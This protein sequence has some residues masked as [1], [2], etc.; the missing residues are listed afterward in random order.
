MPVATLQRQDSATPVAPSPGGQVVSAEFGWTVVYDLSAWSVGEQYAERGYDYVELQSGSS[1]VTLESVIDQHGDPQ[2]CVTDELDQLQMLEDRAAIDLGSDVAEEEPAGMERG[3]AWAVYTVEPL[4][5]ERA[6]QEYTIRFDCY[7][8]VAGGASLVMTHTAPR[9]LWAE[10]RPK[11]DV[12]REGITVPVGSTQD[13]A[14]TAE[15]T[16]HW[17][18]THAM[19]DR[20]WIGHVV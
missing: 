14:L 20:F 9:D 15:R 3:H 16:Y 8:L 2:Q 7:T 18:Y 12:L 19:I 5:E 1:L 11:G 10:E 4:A 13:D 17:R 6:D